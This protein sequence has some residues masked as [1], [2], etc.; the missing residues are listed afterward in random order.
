MPIPDAEVGTSLLLGFG[1]GW[2][3][4]DGGGVG[5]LVVTWIYY[6]IVSLAYQ[7]INSSSHDPHPTIPRVCQCSA[8][9]TL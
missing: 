4:E 6:T 3:G 8:G 5:P 1:F 9:W 7:Y 2:G